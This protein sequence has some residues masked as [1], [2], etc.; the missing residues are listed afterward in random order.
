M[1]WLLIGILWAEETEDTEPV[2][3]LEAFLAEIESTTPQSN[4]LFG[5]GA[6]SGGSP[7]SIWESRYR[8]RGSDRVEPNFEE[9]HP[10]LHDYTEFVNRYYYKLNHPE[11]NWS[12]S[13]QIDQASLGLNKYILDDELL[14]SW[15]LYDSTMFS[16]VSDFIIVPEKVSFSKTYQNSKWEFGDMGAVFGRGIALSIRSN[17]VVDV[18]TTLRGL[19]YTGNFGR[20]EVT[21]LS[22]LT[23]KQQISKYNPNLGISDDISHMVSGGQVMLYGLG[24][25]QVG[26]HHMV[27]SF[28]SQSDRDYPDIL[29]YD[30]PISASVTGADIEIFGL[31]GIDWYFEGD[32]FQYM[33]DA[34]SDSGE[35]PLGYT[36]YGSASMYPGSL[37]ILVEGKISKDSERIN[38]FTSIDNWEVATPPSLEYER[39]ITE[40]SSA[41]VN[42]ND[43]YGARI[44]IDYPVRPAVLTPYV[45]MAYLRDTDLEG[46]HF[47]EV[48]ETIYHPITG[49]QYAEN[50]KIVLMNAGYRIDQRDDSTTHGQDRLAHL[51]AEISFPLFG[52]EG[53]EINTSGWKFW[54]GENPSEHNDFIT[55]QNAFVWRRGEFWDLT[56][57]QDYTT[58]TQLDSIGNITDEIYMAGEVTWKPSTDQTFRLLAGAYKAGIRCSGGQCRTLPGFNGVELAYSTNF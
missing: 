3:D 34:L 50:G 55:V 35:T 2:D 48:P 11:E 44:R 17:K 7:S 25:T 4:Q 47:N 14:R 15:T 30:A 38:R 24:M 41:T 49:V 51:D 54:W 22:G 16:P 26:A 39:M 21:M 43:V 29:R 53:F 12:F 33:A 46:L 28:G 32:V 23:N 52:E 13:V 57:Y 37:V 20:A 6:L 27:A 36:G 40:D 45:S 18:D 42:S 8:Y 1:L 58:N 5:M 31:G 19:K 10:N 56:W 9:S